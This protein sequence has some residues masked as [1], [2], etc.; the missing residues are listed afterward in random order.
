MIEM[1]DL[2]ER[3]AEG[4][5]VAPEEARSIKKHLQAIRE[6]ML[7]AQQEQGSANTAE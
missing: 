1:A 6:D 2:L 3:M 7:R 4:K 5:R